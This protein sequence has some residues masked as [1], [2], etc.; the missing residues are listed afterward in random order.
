MLRVQPN[1]ELPP[2][3]STHLVAPQIWSYFS[4]YSTSFS[5][6]HQFSPFC[7]SPNFCKILYIRSSCTR[8]NVSHVRAS[9]KDV[10]DSMHAGLHGDLYLTD[11]FDEITDSESEEYTLEVPT[12]FLKESIEK[13]RSL[14]VSI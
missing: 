5:M 12:Q 1:F 3:R 8:G 13:I 14:I 6:L 7:Y 10:S 2:Y 11:S 4:D 9:F